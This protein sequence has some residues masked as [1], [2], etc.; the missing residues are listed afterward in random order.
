MHKKKKA[1]IQNNLNFGNL[2]KILALLLGLLLIFFFFLPSPIYSAAWNPPKIPAK[3][4]VLRPNNE[5]LKAEYI[6]RDKVNAPE[7]IAFDSLGRIYTGTKEG[8]I[9][10]ITLKANNQEIIE[11]FAAIPGTHP[12]GLRFDSQENLIV[13]GGKKGLLSVTPQG[14]VIS[15]VT[16]AEG[17]PIHFADDLDIASDGTIYFSDASTKFNEVDSPYGWP[18]DLLEAKPYGRLISYN[19]KTETTKVLLKDLYFANGVTLPRNEESVLVVES[20][21]YRITRYWLKG[22]KAGTWD[23]FAENLPG[24]PDG[25]MSDRRGKIWI[26]MNLPRIEILD[27]LHRQPFLK[28]QLAKLP[29]QI[30]M[31]GVLWLEGLAS[32]YGFVAAAN[33]QGNIILTLQD[34]TGELLML[35]NVVPEEDYI[36]LGTLFGNRIGRYKLP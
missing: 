11:T 6:A 13:A 5:L 3:I 2:S 8:K 33:Q 14:K 35:S 24:I 20:F 15:L 25:I 7:D 26:A 23:Y 31:G 16:E 10:R 4:G 36:Y 19:P 30:W 29:V 9:I 17:I 1:K 32:G 27:R 34:P 22:A 28:N 18:Y 12:L 21:R